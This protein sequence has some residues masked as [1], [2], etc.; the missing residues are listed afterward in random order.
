LIL[1]VLLFLYQLL[2]NLNLKQALKQ[3][4]INLLTVYVDHLCDSLA[5][6]LITLSF[7]HLL[8][9]SSVQGWFV[10]LGFSLVPYYIDHL[11]M[12]YSDRLEFEVVNPVDEGTNFVR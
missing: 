7:S 4:G 5:C 1:L 6:S 8:G 2:D 9:L 11:R 10:L 12:Y 3:G